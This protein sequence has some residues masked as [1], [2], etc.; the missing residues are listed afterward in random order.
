MTHVLQNCDLWEDGLIKCYYVNHIFGDAA[1]PLRRWLLTP[2]RD[3]GHLSAQ[4]KKYN[5]YHSCNRV[6]IEG[7]FALLKSRFRRLHFIDTMSVST[8]VEIIIACCILHNLCLLENDVLNEDLIEED[9]IVGLNANF[10][11]HDAE[12]DLKREQIARNL[13]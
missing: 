9:D 5:H 3:N 7:S 4:Q 8:A 10:K 11:E 13:V 1:Y 2:Y 6:V 12:G